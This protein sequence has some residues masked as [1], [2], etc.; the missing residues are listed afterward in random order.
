MLAAGSAAAGRLPSTSVV[1]TQT[2][3]TSLQMA[4]TPAHAKESLVRAIAEASPGSSLHFLLQRASG[5][6]MI[7]VLAS[8]EG[9][10]LSSRPHVFCSRFPPSP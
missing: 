5:T 9:F 1:E 7:A 2:P 10:S 4:T 8:P 6:H 3:Q